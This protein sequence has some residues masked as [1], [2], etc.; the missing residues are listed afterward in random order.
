MRIFMLVLLLAVAS[1]RA[2]AEP[3]LGFEVDDSGGRLRVSHVYP[4]T[5]AS[6][7]GVAM[8]DIVLNVGGA[9][10]KNEKEFADIVARRKPG[11]VAR[12]RLKRGEVA[13]NHKIEVADG[14]AMRAAVEQQKNA[15]RARRD[16]ERRRAVA[17]REQLE[18][19]I[20]EKGA[21]SFTAGKVTDNVI[22]R[23]EIVLVIE[24]ISEQWIDGVEFR[25]AMF[26]KFGRPAKGLW[27]DSHE[28][29]FLFQNRIGA[30]G[31][32]RMIVPIPW[33]DTVGKAEIVVVQYVLDNGA[34]IKP[35]APDRVTVQR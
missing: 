18:E 8:G 29:T 2:G 26:D 30:L 10:V 20:A 4:F 3:H 32:E 31:T 25:V 27:G 14:D 12:V 13:K 6:K 1:A 5:E 21:V 7:A 22:G 19:R 17:E 16:Q 9:S 23:P 33:H 34:I 35:T 11:D 24:N 28:K 15:E